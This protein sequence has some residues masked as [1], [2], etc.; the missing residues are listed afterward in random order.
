MSIRSKLLAAFGALLLVTVGMGVME[1]TTLSSMTGQ[2]DGLY[3]NNLQATTYLADA[4]RGM[5]ELRFGLPNYYTS[6]V[7]SRAMIKVASE[8]WL[9]QVETNLK[10]FAA[11]ELMPEE[12]DLLAEFWASYPLYVQARPRFFELMDLGKE[13]E[14][15]TFRATQTN[16]PAA[17]SV[18]T[19]SKLIQLQRR[20]GEQK[21]KDFE[22]QAASSQRALEIFLALAVVLGAVFSVLM[23]RSITVP[24]ERLVRVSE[25]IASGRL[26]ETVEVTSTDELGRLQRAIRDMTD[27]LSRTIREVNN[28]AL[29]LSGAAGQVSA[30]AQSLS[31][32]TSEQAASV[33]ETS[34]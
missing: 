2:F 8:K 1:Y 11:L 13:E 14:A 33:E 4:E 12:K 31:Q 21:R 24:M 32:G 15:K 34:S 22:A 6:E 16:P 29:A 28:S 20:D 3:N 27:Q 5:W 30:T 25:R 18:A 10:A 7:D 19:L 23:G 26:N 9:Q 17:R